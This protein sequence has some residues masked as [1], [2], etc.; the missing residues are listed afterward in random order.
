[1]PIQET[2]EIHGSLVS[3][4]K[5]EILYQADIKDVFPLQSI[6]PITL[7]TLP[8]TVVFAH[9]D[10]SNPMSKM[11]LMLAEIPP[12]IRNIR[13]RNRRYRLGMPWTYFWF[14]ATTA[15]DI[16]EPRWNL[17]FWRI[18]H[19]KDRYEDEKTKLIP[20]RCPNVYS[21]G[22]ICWGTAGAPGNIPLCDRIDELVTNWYIS[23]FNGDLD[24]SVPLPNH[25]NN[26]LE[27]VTKTRE[28]PT[29]WKSWSDW[30]DPTV[31]VYTVEQLISEHVDNPAFS[32]IVVPNMIPAVDMTTQLTYGHW[33][34]YFR[35]AIPEQQRARALRALENLRD[36]NPTAFS[37]EE[38][39]SDDADDGGVPI[40]A[41][42]AG[43]NN[44]RY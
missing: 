25:A 1:M 35:T 7:P 37:D 24:G 2:I 11:L 31:R 10:E 9:F 28:D 27:W 29:W 32:T 22:R 13:K 38:E 16:N 3:Y 30:T 19:A 14:V 18:F 12:G 43:I 4:V 23:E 26:Y 21:D 17:E 44:D 41:F 15:R 8:R 6:K 36:D 40:T 34:Q 39:D 20:A 42:E 33:E 5:K